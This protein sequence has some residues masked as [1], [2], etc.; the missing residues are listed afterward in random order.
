M[1]PVKKLLAA[2]VDPFRSEKGFDIR[3]ILVFGVM[4]GLVLV[5]ACL[6]DPRIGYD[7]IANLDY[8]QAL[9]RL[10]LVT[11][12]DSYEFFSPPLPYGFPALAITITGMELFWAAKLAQYLN[13]FLSVGSTLYL[14]KTCHLI[15][16][17]ASLKLGA[18]V[19]LGILPVYY[20]TFAFVRGEPYVLFFTM[21]I[22][23]DTLL[24]LVREQYTVA[25]G[26][27]LGTAMGLCALS[28]QWGIFLFPSVLLLLAFQWVRL[29]HRRWAITKTAGICLMLT[30]VIGGWFYLSLR[31]RYGSGTAF[32]RQP[33]EQF[34]FD[35]Q[36]AKFYT[37]LGLGELFRKPVRPNFANQFMPMFYSELWGDYWCYFTIYAR[38]SRTSEFLSGYTLNQIIK[39][40]NIPGWLD[41]NY[42]KVSAYLGRVNLVSI[43]PSLVILVSCI[44]AVKG[45]LR[46]RSNEPLIAHPR[47]IY[48]FLLLTIGTSM[49]GYFWFLIMYPNLEKGDTIK[50]MYVLQVFPFIA[51]LVGALFE[52]VKMKSQLFYRLIVCGLGL[53]FIHNLP[54]MLTHYRL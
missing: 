23:Y 28:R 29:P 41:T 26:I 46:R 32:N 50:A 35:N 36:P 47:T 31:M 18:L 54:A 14:I 37:G 17:R 7:A 52:Q 21:L 20:K 42:W 39:Q 2:F 12:F 40:G 16:S 34:S 6:H 27:L 38:D 22:L 10:H 9:S 25:N 8:I 3:L 13:V 19:F 49:V 43:F 45:I 1:K 33:A 15:S 48:A 5:N 4:N 44:S 30:A 51:I 11:P 24:M 53:T